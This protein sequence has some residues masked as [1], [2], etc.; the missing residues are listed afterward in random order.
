MALTFGSLRH[1]SSGR[2]RKPLPTAKRYTPKFTELTVADTYRRDTKHYSSASNTGG[3]CEAA[4]R[5][6]AND[7]DF[8]VAPAYNKGAYQVISKENI[9]D[10]GR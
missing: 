9:K 3:T 5:S 1:T 4:D 6:Y 7:A 10:I 2:K 8:T